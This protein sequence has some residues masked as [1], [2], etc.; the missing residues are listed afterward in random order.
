KQIQLEVHVGAVFRNSFAGVRGAPQGG[1]RLA[2]LDVLARLQIVADL[3]Q[4]GVERV[5]LQTVNPV[6][7]HKVISVVGER[8]FGA[9]ID[10]GAVGGGQHRVGR[11]APGIAL[12]AFDVEAFV[13]LRAVRAHTTQHA[14]GPRFADGAGK[15]RSEEHTSELQSP[16]HLV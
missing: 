2:G 13:H 4:V 7:Q 9:E 3:F 14:G 1:D 5:N 8:R 16:D 15:K 11:L 6:T 12:K 10:H